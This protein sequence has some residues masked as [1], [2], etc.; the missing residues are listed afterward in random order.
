[1]DNID[2]HGFDKC[3]THLRTFIACSFTNLYIFGSLTG[4][5]IPSI[6]F[7]MTF[8]KVDIGR[9]RKLAIQFLVA[10]A[11]LI[12]PYAQVAVA[13]SMGGDA[14][15]LD[16]QMAMDQ[17]Q[18]EHHGHAVI[19]SSEYVDQSH[20][21]SDMAT[22]CCD[23]VCI[24]FAFCIPSYTLTV[25]LA[26]QVRHAIVDAEVAYGEWFLPHRPPNS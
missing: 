9:L 3:T 18:H 23:V 14:F 17:D 6:L 4:F 12:S 7:A 19:D 22:K 26:M 13:S 5:A 1:M 11:L 21:S 15:A 2:S 10:L 25:R 20:W 16:H 8:A 24:G